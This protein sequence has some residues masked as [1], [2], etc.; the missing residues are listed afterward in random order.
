M[1]LFEHEIGL[2][3]PISGQKW[4]KSKKLKEKSWIWS[5]KGVWA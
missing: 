3:C 5:I 4:F 1:A 2:K